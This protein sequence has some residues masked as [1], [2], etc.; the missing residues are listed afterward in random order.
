MSSTVETANEIRPFQVDIPEEAL[1]DLRRRIAATRWPSRELVAD[2]S[3][4]VQS[5]TIQ[6][7]AR[8][9]TSEYD[10]RKCEAETERA[11][12]V[13]DRDRRGRDPLHPRQVA[14]RERVAA[15]HD[16]RL[17][18]LG[19][20]AARHHRPPDRPDRARRHPRGRVPPG[21]AVLAWLRLLGRADRARLGV[22]PHRT[23]VGGADAS[24]RLQPLCRPGRR[25]GCPRHGLDGPPGG[26]GFGR[27]PPEPA[28]G[29]AGNRRSTAQG[30]RTGTRS[31]RGG[32]DVQAG[33]LRLLPRDG[34]EATDDRLR[35]AGFTRRP[36]GLVARP[37]HRQLLQDLPRVR[38]RRA[39]G[40]SHPGQHPRQHHAV[41]ADRHRSVGGPVVLGGRTSAG[42]SACERPAS[43]GGQGAGRLHHVPR[44][45]LGVA[46]ELGRG[47]LPRPRLLQRGRQGRPLRRLGRAASCSPKRSGPRSGHCA[48]RSEGT[49]VG[50]NLP[51]EAPRPSPRLSATSTATEEQQMDQDAS[52]WKTLL[53]RANQ[54]VRSATHPAAEL[55]VEGHL[56]GFDGATGWLNSRATDRGRPARPRR[57]G[58][59]LDLHLHQLA[60]D[61]SLC[62]RLGR[63][64]QGPGP[65][66]D[67]RP[68]PR[69]RLRARPRQRPPRGQGPG[70]RLPGRDR[71]RLRDLDRLRATTT[72]RRCTSS[73]P[74]G[75]SAT[76]AS[77]RATTRCPR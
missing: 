71:Q 45:D 24:P 38:R 63:Q 5:A 34:N 61:A 48:S 2:R 55:P 35:P 46:P 73:T 26:R 15:D 37:R 10:W 7:L 40:Q 51:Q 70:G 18:R 36:G 9:W 52:G 76:T 50:H 6:A 22:R 12:A 25:R 29:G 28:H 43:S 11:A 75:R 21:A 53:T 14:A 20:R 57:A 47:G 74:K 65:D 31:G 49:G 23:R 68:H 64:V 44:R 33:R 41:L 77:A 42:R 56:P 8:Y 69:V 72:G 54:L 17:A 1:E 32:R 30:I 59:L 19:H 58:Q 3:Q 4:G 62:P 66:R 60:A 16:P 39:R 27:L 67:R 13:H